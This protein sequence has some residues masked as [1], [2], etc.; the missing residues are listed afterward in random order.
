MPSTPSRPAP[1]L[2]LTAAGFSPVASCVHMVEQQRPVKP[3][4][5]APRPDTC[6]RSSAPAASPDHARARRSV[7]RSAWRSSALAYRVCIEQP[8]GTIRPLRRPAI[9]AGHDLLSLVFSLTGSLICSPD[10]SLAILFQLINLEGSGR[11]GD[12]S[13][14]GL[15][16]LTDFKQY[17][18][19]YLMIFGPDRGFLVKQ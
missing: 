18:F 1:P 10:R 4:G 6:R 19:T 3:G 5:P 2:Q 12:F 8:L 15:D 7:R 11:K 17:I 13:P 9:T 16:D 14:I